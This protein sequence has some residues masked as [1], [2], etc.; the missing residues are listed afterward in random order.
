MLENDVIAAVEWHEPGA[1]I[2]LASSRPQSKGTT[3]SRRLCRTSVGTFTLSNKFRT[4]ILLKASVS[5]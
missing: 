5:R 2:P 3:A 1:S 4:S